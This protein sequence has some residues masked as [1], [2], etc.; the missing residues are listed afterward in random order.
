MVET[1]PPSDERITPKQFRHWL[2]RR[3][4]EDL[5][6]YELINGRIVM[7]PPAGWPH[8]SVEGALV[9]RLYRHV[10]TRQLGIVLGSSA[11]YQLPTGDILEPDVSFLSQ[12]RLTAGPSPKR[13]QFL[14]ICPTLVVEI[15]SDS[16]AKRDRT[17]KKDVYARNRVDEYWL[18]DTD[19]GE[20]TVFVLQGERYTPGETFRSGRVGSRVLPDLELTVEEAL[21]S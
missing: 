9:G 10:S 5:H 21:A 8:G 16:T 11:G 4:A 7:T 19:Q 12:Q 13:G 15:L 14:R 18:V 6:H 17:E 3:P 20:I 2:D 1:P